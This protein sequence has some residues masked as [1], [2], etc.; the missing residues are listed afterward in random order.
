M[1]KGLFGLCSHV[2]YLSAARD[3]DHARIAIEL[4]TREKCEKGKMLSFFFFLYINCTQTLMLGN[5]K[6]LGHQH[7]VAHCTSA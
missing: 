4:L 3:I 1:K 5:F 7:I 6:A 2:H